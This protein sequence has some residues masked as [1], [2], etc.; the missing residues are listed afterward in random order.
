[1]TSRKM[2]IALIIERANIALGGA[3]RSVFDTA[4][5]L[6]AIGVE[7]E[8]LAAKG[9]TEA[10]NVQIL[11]QQYPGKRVCYFSFVKALRR[12]MAQRHYDIVHSVLPFDFADI[13][14]PRGGSFAESVLRNAASYQNRFIESYKR[15]TA[16]AN[17][18]RTILRRAEKKLCRNPA[19][20]MVVA[21]SK[22][23]A[24]QFKQHYG[25]T[26][27]RIV[28][29]PNGVKIYKQID[30]AESE[31]LRKQ[32]M[33]QL[34][35]KET[36][37]PVLFL[38]V[39][40]NFRLKGLACLIK[41]MQLTS[42]NGSEREVYLIVA[43]D[44]R[45]REYQ[46][47]AEKINIHKKIMFLGVVQNIQDA[48]SAIDV[49]VLPTF[50]DPSSRYVLEALAANKPVITTKFNGATDLFINDRHGKVIDSPENISALAEAISYFTN[51][52]NIQKA[53]EAIVADNIK[54]KISIV[55]VAKE[56]KSL[57]EEIIEK[58]RK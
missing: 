55:R 46:N 19:G 54:E 51:I 47:L 37:N 22:Y 52:D 14:Q 43:G 31:S 17:F 49:A 39:A 5:G 7:V 9:Q 40:N 27:K 53:S 1:M 16:F 44:D 42:Q 50:Y 18:R 32:I 30:V 10:D 58:R 56:L 3:E 4:D 29:I 15:I 8:I 36:N 33:N 12:Y 28:V 20:P 45:I 38:F 26:G 23:V 21:I 41:A 34:G 11:C 57:Y 24:E 48:I 25:L 2:K 6:S 13:Y 35:L